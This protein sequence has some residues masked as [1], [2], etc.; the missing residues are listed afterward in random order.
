MKTFNASDLAHKRTEI[1]EAAKA[2]GAILQRK[3]TNGEV[4]DE[5]VI[6]S[7][8]ESAILKL[9]KSHDECDNPQC[10]YCSFDY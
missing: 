7:V 9:E 2:D 8:A 4:L 1:F 3:N 5:F 10:Q 6:M